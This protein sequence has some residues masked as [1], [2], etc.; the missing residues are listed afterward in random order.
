MQEQSAAL[1]DGDVDSD[2]R[3]RDLLAAREKLSP[4][5]AWKNTEVLHSMVQRAMEAIRTPGP[6]VPKFGSSRRIVLLASDNR[7]KEPEYRQHLDL[8]GVELHRI[9]PLD[10]PAYYKAFLKAGDENLRILNVIREESQIVKVGG[11][12][13][14]RRKDC[15][16]VENL[17]VLTAYSLQKGALEAMVYEHRTEGY[18]DLSRRRADR[19]AVFGWDDI[20][21]LKNSGFTYQELA[22]KGFKFSSRNMVLSD[23]IRDRL[24]YREVV[25]LDFHPLSIRRPIDFS[26]SVLDFVRSNPYFNNTAACEIGL[27]R[28]FLRVALDGVFFRAAENRREKN[29]WLPG[30]NAGI[31]LVPKK[32]AIHEITFMAH[33]F[34]HFAI[35]DL[36]FTGVHSEQHRRVYIAARMMS[37]AITLV[38]A[39]MLFVDT[40]SR[41]GIEYDFSKRRIYPLFEAVGIK[42]DDPRSLQANLK[43]LLKA[44]A[45]YCLRGDDSPYHELI[46]S[47]GGDFGA[48]EAF[49]E[50]YMPF[51][52]ED[53]RWTDRNWTTM[54][55]RSEVMQEWWRQVAPLRERGQISIDTV[56]EFTARLDPVG[57]LVES[58]FEQIFAERIA[59]FLAQLAEPVEI[60]EA[61][62]ARA[63]GKAFYRYMLGQLSLFAEYGFL[64]EAQR[65][66]E[67][68]TASL[69]EKGSDFNQ[70][71]IQRVRG[72]YEQFVHLLCERNFLSRDDER[73]YIEIYPLFPPFYVFYDEEQ[74]FYESLDQIS[75]RLLSG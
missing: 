2:S 7:R 18:I 74:G 28:L 8:Y 57:D 55:G 66:R 13:P 20:F 43:A 38:L 12:E 44:N 69:Y 33:D 42:L 67:K 17:A 61:A 48:L 15:E 14:G 19:A 50:K 6:D 25:H 56:E 26:C 49:K 5:D 51:F 52:V 54:V 65:Y 37:E 36:V 75:S 21:V 39:D 16:P 22:E 45:A 63:T 59:P 27:N 53:F 70:E 58:V 64:P 73:T 35:P 10:H 3:L 71:E 34:C 32:D 68:I 40:L 24:H 62:A 47:H 46:R 30:L 23:F 4:D 60:G 29:Y 31:P 1:P 72:L 9:P 41:S 11:R